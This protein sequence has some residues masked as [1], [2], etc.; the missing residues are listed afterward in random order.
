MICK[1]SVKKTYIF[2]EMNQ[3]WQVVNNCWIL[4][5]GYIGCSVY[6]KFFHNREKSIT[7]GI[8]SIIIWALVW[9]V[10]LAKPIHWLNR[11]VGIIH[12][13]ER[14][15]RNKCNVYFYLILLYLAWHFNFLNKI[16]SLLSCL[17]DDHIGLLTYW[18]LRVICL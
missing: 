6:L 8:L 12:F 5:V 11:W 9:K 18:L 14:D 4:G 3:R 2:V 1:W 17:K 15:C 16:F 10:K 7:S 13:C